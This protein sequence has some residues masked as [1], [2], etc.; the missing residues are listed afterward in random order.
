MAVL[1][2]R[3]STV[4]CVRGIPSCSKHS[5]SHRHA[6]LHGC[7]LRWK[8][9]WW[10]RHNLRVLSRKLEKHRMYDFDGVR[11]RSRHFDSFLLQVHIE[12]M[13]VAA[14]VWLPDELGCCH[15]SRIHT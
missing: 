1:Y 4:H 7:D 12:G 3:L 13:G 15:W 9:Q 6:I 10:F 2:L 5:N 11:L 14:G 8:V